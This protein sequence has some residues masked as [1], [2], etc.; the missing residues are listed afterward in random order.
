MSGPPSGRAGVGL[1]AP[2]GL[3]K[4]VLTRGALRAAPCTRL[5]LCARRQATAPSVDPSAIIWKA[6]CDL[7]RFLLSLSPSLSNDQCVLFIVKLVIIALSSYSKLP[8]CRA[9]MSA[10]DRD[11][12]V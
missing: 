9:L 6:F 2:S 4:W 12:L 1:Q 7:W 10:L 11:Y 5:S 3:W 8:V